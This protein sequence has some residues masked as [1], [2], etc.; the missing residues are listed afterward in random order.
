MP[1]TFNV[2]INSPPYQNVD[3]MV[4]DT[5]SEELLDGYIDELGNT[6]KRPGLSS[7]IKLGSFKTVDGGYWWDGK[8][9][10]LFN[11]DG[12]IY[13]VSDS[14]GTVV[15]ITNT[16]DKIETSGRAIFADNGS[17]FVAANGGR[18]VYSDGAANTAYITDVDAPTSVTHVAFL[19]QYLLAN[20]VNTGKFHFCDFSSSPTTW[21]A[22]DVF[23]AESLPDNLVALYVNKRI[24]ILMGTQSIE[25]WTNDGV[26]PFSRINGWTIQRGVMS[27]YCTVNVN[28]IIYFFDD[29]RKLTILDGNSHK[30]LNTSYDRTIQGFDTVSDCT[31]DYEFFNGQNK[32]RYIFP[33]EQRT[34]I[35]NLDQNYWSEETYY[36]SSVDTRKRYLGSCYIYARDWNQHLVGSYL[37]DD[38][39]RLDVSNFNDNGNQIRVK[40]V[41]GHIDHGYPNK[42]KRSY[43][44]TFRFKM[45]VGL[46]D[47]GNTEPLVV[48]RFR[49]DGSSVWGN[50]IHIPL[51]VLGN[52]EF[53]H[54]LYNLGSYYSRQYEI[55]FAQDA[56]FIMGKC[57]EEVDISE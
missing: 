31:A 17:Y 9:V 26:S 14:N 46:G 10:A 35:Y 4:L 8:G 47:S 21:S 41:T 49:D 52:T 3:G 43:S 16:G 55:S 32:I 48:I 56:P 51:K 54:T 53:S 37:V 42:R 5:L 34:L 20:N 30:T 7:Y 36:D 24:I 28:G 38:I 45:G 13:K 11:S 44:L 19:D 23:T 18:M 27:K 40:K 15:N 6:N 39:L 33:T 25:F 1:K 22:L 2:P 12:S 29:K 57:L 50:F